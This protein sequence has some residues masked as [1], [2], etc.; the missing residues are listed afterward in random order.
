[1]RVFRV[2][3][4]KGTEFPFFIDEKNF[5]FYKPATGELSGAFTELSDA[6]KQIRKYI[7]GDIR[8]LSHYS[9]TKTHTIPENEG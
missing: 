2:T 3:P 4:L 9:I 7:K 6:I 1:M 5:I 8:V